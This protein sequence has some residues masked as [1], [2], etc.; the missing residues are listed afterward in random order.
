MSRV[1]DNFDRLYA[2]QT[3]TIGVA[4]LATVDGYASGKP[5]ILSTIATNDIYVDGGTATDGGYEL[6]M[7]ASDFGTEPPK[8]TRV[9]CNGD[10]AGIELE[11]MDVDTSNGIYLIKLASFA[12][13]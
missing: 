4:I 7:K 8:Q 5:A 3:R 11:V 12:A 2:A 6:Q 10:A 1:T 13:V 9:T